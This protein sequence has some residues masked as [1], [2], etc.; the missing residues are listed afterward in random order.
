M[1]SNAVPC[2][3]LST[4]YGCEAVQSSLSLAE[5]A[6]VPALPVP[7]PEPTVSR[8][9]IISFAYRNVPISK[10][11][12]LTLNPLLTN[13]DGS[14]WDNLPWSTWSIDPDRRN[15][16][17]AGNTILER[18]HLGKRDA[19]NRMMGKDWP[20][21]SLSVGNLVAKAMYLL[22][23]DDDGDEGGD[24]NAESFGTDAPV[25][26]DDDAAHSLARRILE[27][28]ARE[29]R[30]E[31]A[32]AEQSLAVLR[33]ELVLSEGDGIWEVA[34][35]ADRWALAGAEDRLDD[36]RS[37][38]SAAE[39][40]LKALDAPPGGMGNFSSEVQTLL[41]GLLSALT[42]DKPKA[43]YRGAI[44]Y[45]PTI[46]SREEMLRK[47]VLP[48][49]GPYDL[50]LEI[51]QEQL[52]ADIIGTAIENT[53]LFQGTLIL[54]GVV[55]LRRRGRKREVI[56]DGEIAV[57]EDEDDDFGNYATTGGQTFLVECDADEAI[58]MALAAGVGVSVDR[59]IWDGAGT[60]VTNVIKAGR[61]D[62]K[63]V[64]EAIT[65]MEAVGAGASIETLGSAPT[66]SEERIT[67]QAPKTTNAFFD[68]FSESPLPSPGSSR[69]SMFPTDNPVQTLAEY[70]ALSDEGKARILL[71]LPSF[72]GRLP[73]PRTLREA[74]VGAG[75][76]SSD[77]SA[78]AALLDPLDE[79]LVPLVDESV[80]RSVLIRDAEQRGDEAEARA[81]REER[82]PRQRAK[83]EA[84]RARESELGGDGEAEMWDEKADLLGGLR[85]DVTQDE[86]SYS[87]FLDKDE[88]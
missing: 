23:S 40:A 75:P 62:R 81:L 59:D 36:A 64:M 28:E 35:D 85:A 14:L 63:S 15:Y 4:E 56:I 8:L 44:G 54:G 21:R 26:F 49:T 1:S 38:I 31:A 60:T 16:D 20:G 82:S 3:F 57:A 19:Y 80:R 11:L 45:Q 71:S 29:A 33:A 84:D 43:P 88:W 34:N 70:D 32:D 30:Y 67:P 79:L 39:E 7:L 18:Y 61:S 47:S 10:S 87:R 52:N 50:L 25:V 66:T 53:S 51:I 24:G 76:N 73:R 17:A 5:A 12:C 78:N 22:E 42:D 41:S 65:E 72:E 69:P 86:G 77:L 27:M 13:R 83:E 68:I 46:D 9:K 74:R 55:V 2:L 6:E 37:R 58:G 48:Y